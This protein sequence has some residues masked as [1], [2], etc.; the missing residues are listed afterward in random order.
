MHSYCKRNA[1]CPCFPIQHNLR[2]KQIYHSHIST[3]KTLHNKPIYFQCH[4]LIHL[5]LLGLCPKMTP[6]F[7]NNCQKRSILLPLILDC[8]S[9]VWVAMG[10]ITEGTI[11]CL[12]AVAQPNI[13]ILWSFKHNRFLF[14]LQEW[15]QVGAITERLQ[16]KKYNYT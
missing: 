8:C 1:T 12:L 2:S 13:H 10:A 15:T 6:L 4:S 14:D 3:S 16:E 5:Q 9:N 7:F 11:V